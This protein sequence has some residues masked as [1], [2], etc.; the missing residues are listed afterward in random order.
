VTKSVGDVV[1]SKLNDELDDLIGSMDG[2]GFGDPEAREHYQ[3]KID[4]LKFRITR[5][6][7]MRIAIVSATIG[8][9]VAAVVTV[10]TSILG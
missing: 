4:L 8:A 3:R 9:I 5:R 10:L 2:G 6:D 1:L 7:N